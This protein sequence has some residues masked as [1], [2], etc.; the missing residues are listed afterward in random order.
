M[1]ESNICNRK[2]MRVEDKTNV[3]SSPVLAVAPGMTQKVLGVSSGQAVQGCCRGCDPAAVTVGQL[4]V[5]QAHAW[6]VA[7]GG[8]GL[9][10]QTLGDMRQKNPGK[11]TDR[12]TFVHALFF[13]LG[14]NFGS[15]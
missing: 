9:G 11:G 12:M 10:R 1:D 4:C 8:G 5:P 14:H 13:T 6:H 3:I 2:V 7:A 15:I